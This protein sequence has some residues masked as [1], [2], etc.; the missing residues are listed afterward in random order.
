MFRFAFERHVCCQHVFLPFPPPGCLLQYDFNKWEADKLKS[1]TSKSHQKVTSHKLHQYSAL[2]V[3]PLHLSP[4][5]NPPPN[6]HPSSPVPRLITTPHH[7]QTSE[8]SVAA[9]FAFFFLFNHLFW[10]EG[11]RGDRHSYSWLWQGS[12]ISE[13]ALKCLQSRA[14]AHSFTKG[15]KQLTPHFLADK[16]PG[17]NGF[18]GHQ[19]TVA[20]TCP[21][22]LKDAKQVTKSWQ[23]AEGGGIIKPKQSKKH[24]DSLIESLVL[25]SALPKVLACL[26]CWREVCQDDLFVLHIENKRTCRKI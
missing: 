4:S 17:G 11:A 9:L 20:V 18:W 16:Q 13:R 23:W 15:Q 1:A 7:S 14:S 21:T 12:H 19:G 24:V 2:P 10:A 8:L 25:H 5:A 3:P 6:M 22:A 26:R